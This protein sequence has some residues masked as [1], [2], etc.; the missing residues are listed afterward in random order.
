[1]S[2]KRLVAQGERQP[3]KPR[4]FAASFSKFSEV[5]PGHL[6][7]TKRGRCLP[8]PETGNEEETKGLGRTQKAILELLRKRPHNVTELSHKLQKDRHYIYKALRGFSRR[9]LLA[10]M[11]LHGQSLSGN[12][13][14]LRYFYLRGR[15]SEDDV[16]F[17]ANLRHRIAELAMQYCYERSVISWVVLDS[18]L[19][20]ISLAPQKPSPSLG[21][22]TAPTQEKR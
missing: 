9:G 20:I 13:F 12:V 18:R 10:D 15:G 7:I 6:L 22:A 1:M 16:Q 2:N 8:Q 3:A 5:G 21:P 11:K 4:Q 14:P 19:K 17:L